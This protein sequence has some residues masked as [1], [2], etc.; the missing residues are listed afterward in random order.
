ML[1]R[2]HLAIA[3]TTALATTVLG[4][5]PGLAA[6]SDEAAVSA[7]VE[8]F[9]AAMVAKDRKALTE[10]T[11]STLSYGHSS[12]KIQDKAVFIEGAMDPKSTW[13]SITLSDQTV[14]VAGTNAISRFT[15]TGQNDSGGKTNDVKLGI[16]MVWVKQRGK[17]RLLARQGYK[18]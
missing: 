11:A 16:L 7:A 1:D 15:F 13:K 4:L 10:L 3:V 14:Q 18:V 2:R 8:A 9:R 5:V 12:G 6:T 17:W